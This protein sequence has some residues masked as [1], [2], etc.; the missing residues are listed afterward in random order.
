MKTQVFTIFSSSPNDRDLAQIAAALKKGAVM[1]YPTDT[2]YALGCLSNNAVALDKLARLKDIKLER[3]PLS[4]LFKD[5][6]ELSNYVKPFEGKLES[7]DYEPRNATDDIVA[8]ILD[9]Y[10]EHQ[11]K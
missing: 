4:F 2:V 7:W 8:K 6:S 3:A 11:I 9:A 1:I 10:H 5:I